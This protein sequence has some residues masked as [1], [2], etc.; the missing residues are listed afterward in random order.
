MIAHRMSHVWTLPGGVPAPVSTLVGRTEELADSIR[1]LQGSR[2]L[3]VTGAGGSGA[4][5]GAAA[6]LPVPVSARHQPGAARHRR[7]AHLA[8]PAAVGT[9]P[10]GCRGS[11]SSGAG[12]FGPAV[13]RA[14]AGGGTGVSAFP[15]EC[16]RG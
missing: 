14:R 9:V 1:L 16:R 13:R 6:R 3:T 7:R 5:R 15:L 11:G 4:R 12:R 10:G 2:L 8:D